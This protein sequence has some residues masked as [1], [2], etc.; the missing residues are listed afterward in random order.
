MRNR[1]PTGNAP[2]ERQTGSAARPPRSSPQT[3]YF[4]GF[5]L[6]TIICTTCEPLRYPSCPVIRT[7][8]DA[9][10]EKNLRR[11]YPGMT[12]PRVPRQLCITVEDERER[13]MQLL[14]VVAVSFDHG[15]SKRER[16]RR[17]EPRRPLPR[18]DDS[19]CRVAT[20]YHGGR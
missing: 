5:T 3:I 7:P 14:G 1:S 19:S 6:K 9:Q 2:T 12:I 4:P 15:W 11:L 10:G 18:D 20:V 13:A 17:Y 16:E 8:I